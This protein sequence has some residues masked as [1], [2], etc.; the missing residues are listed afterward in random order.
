MTLTAGKMQCI[1]NVAGDL[2]LY[3]YSPYLI[4]CIRIYARGIGDTLSAHYPPNIPPQIT[5]GSRESPTQATSNQPSLATHI[6]TILPKQPTKPTTP[7]TP[8]AKRYRSWASDMDRY[9]S[10]TADRNVSKQE[11]IRPNSDMFNSS[12]T[13]PT[14]SSM[15]DLW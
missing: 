10:N 1:T 6:H 11:H 15:Q 4:T 14:H 2:P 12:L 3:H 8:K 13:T 5:Q 7:V 9:D